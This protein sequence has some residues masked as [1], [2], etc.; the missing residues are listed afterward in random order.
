MSQ[1]F[2]S[3]ASH[4]DP[5]VSELR[6]ALESL[7]IST[8]VD[9][10]RLRAGETLKPEI[11]QAIEGAQYVLA[12]LGTTTIN[13]HWV[14]LE[15]QHALEFAKQRDDDYRVIPL[16]LTGLEPTA[17]WPWFGDEEPVAILVPEGDHRVRKVLPELA[18]ALGQALPRDIE[19]WKQPK[20]PPVAELI[21][22]LED[23][24]LDENFRATAT[25]KLVFV[26][27]EGSTERRVES[28]R[29]SFTAP[30][31]PIEKGEID[32]YL[33]SYHRWPSGVFR[34]RARKVET[35]LEAWG[36]KLAEPLLSDT[37]REPF[38]A[39][40]RADATRRFSILVDGDPVARSSE[41]EK[42]R[43]LEGATLLLSLPWELIRDDRGYLL[44]G[45]RPVQVRRRLPNRI[46]V[47]PLITDAP[48][49]VL[50]V[51]PRPEDE[52]AT[53]L[54]HR[55][56]ARALVDALEPLGDSVVDYKMLTPPTFQAL[57]EELHRAHQAGR[58][59]DIVH[60]DGHGVFSR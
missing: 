56:S 45:A 21:L 18:S 37:A 44:Q 30:L 5:I 25:A 24:G 15:I 49:R 31:G 35:E 40:R 59:Y 4:D 41:D 48:I 52:R 36:R 17:L 47:E 33:E 39:W 54:D 22:E 14:R 10:R 27:P 42:K 51:S 19:K 1:V 55:V 28:K 43:V 9:S 13:S 16:L 34:D 2:I 58:P 8:W 60:F 32:W 29:F 26:P 6:E 3:H 38:E 57:G 12:V 7:G 46:V 53:Y 23:P 50:L 20:A 11:L